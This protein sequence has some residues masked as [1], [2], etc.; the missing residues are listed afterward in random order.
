[1][2]VRRSQSEKLRFCF[3]NSFSSGAS[4][5]VLPTLP[6]ATNGI[7]KIEPFKGTKRR[8]RKFGGNGIGGGGGSGIVPI[9]N[10][11]NSY[12]LVEGI[13]SKNS[14]EDFVD[15]FSV[16]GNILTREGEKLLVPY[17]SESESCFIQKYPLEQNLMNLFENSV[18]FWFETGT[19][20]KK[21]PSILSINAPSRSLTWELTKALVGKSGKSNLAIIPFSM[22]YELFQTCLKS[23][24]SHLNGVR[25]LGDFIL[26]NITTPNKKR[27]E[28]ISTNSRAVLQV[29]EYL[30][31]CLEGSKGTRESEKFTLLIDGFEE[32]LETKRGGE[33][34]LRDLSNWTNSFESSGGRRIIFGGRNQN[35]IEENEAVEIEE[36]NEENGQ[37]SNNLSSSIINL[38]SPSSNTGSNAGS[39]N[40]SNRPSASSPFQVITDFF[41]K[42]SKSEKSDENVSNTNVKIEGTILKLFVNGP[43]ND[44]RRFL[45]YSQI[46][47][48]DRKKDIFDRNLLLLKSIVNNRWNM[49]FKSKYDFPSDYS[50]IWDK[51]SKSGKG[52]LVKKKLT[53]DEINEIIFYVLGKEKKLN[54]ENLFEAIENVS[55]IRFD[56]TKFSSHDLSHLLA[57]RQISMNSLT[58]Y[59]KRFINCISTA[60]TQTHFDDIS[61]PEKTM[62]TLRSLTTL[63]LTHPELFTQGVL[64]NSLT[65]VLLFGPPG[66]GKT[67]LARAVAQESGAAFL[68]VNMSNI[69]DMWVGEGEKNIKVIEDIKMVFLSLF[70][71]CLVWLGSWVLQ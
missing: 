30:F 58:K 48:L 59:E 67:M 24:T 37:N 13:N 33:G 36:S 52:I 1:M 41:I 4:V 9:G 15:L 12:G 7:V 22:F 8:S 65:G 50:E 70:R 40:G 57:E 34:I 26:N 23:R 64:K 55:E 56:P 53:R 5:P 17:S 27:N 25:E 2:I 69:F 20:E 45:K 11:S 18:R 42:A 35:L 16:Y 47:G 19:E 28:V 38:G 46:I 6:V 39:S 14:R 71:D 62:T 49:K 3:R 66:T 10:P 31:A 60:T 21:L 32:F 44:K 63:P 68:A 43:K 51:L 54:V 61:L 29:V